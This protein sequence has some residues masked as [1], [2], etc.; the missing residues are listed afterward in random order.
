MGTRTINFAL[1]HPVTAACAM[2]A[3]LTLLAAHV[4]SCCI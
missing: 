4:I 2:F 1:R 3:G